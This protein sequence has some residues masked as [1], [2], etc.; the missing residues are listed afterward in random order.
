LTQEIFKNLIQISLR[1]NTLRD[2][3]QSFVNSSRSRPK[4]SITFKKD[5]NTDTF[6]SDGCDIIF[7][8]Y[9]SHKKK[10]SC[11]CYHCYN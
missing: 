5:K 9:Y 10:F 4:N 11:F 3:L 8:L 7:S 6:P 2:Y 1:I